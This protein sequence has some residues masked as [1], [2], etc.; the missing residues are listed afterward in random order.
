MININVVV[1]TSLYQTDSLMQTDNSVDDV[2][3]KHMYN[4]RTSAGA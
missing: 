4:P 3:T 2:V 1:F